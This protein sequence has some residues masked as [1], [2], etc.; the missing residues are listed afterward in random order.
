MP[1][2]KNTK[3]DAW[4]K[5][6]PIG[7]F[8][9]NEEKKDEKDK[10][11]RREQRKEQQQRKDEVIA[12]KFVGKEYAKSSPNQVPWKKILGE[13]I[14]DR[15]HKLKNKGHSILAVIDILERNISIQKF[16]KENP[17][18]KNKVLT[19]IEYNVKNRYHENIRAKKIEVSY[20]N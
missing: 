15:I 13:S 8:K 11:R 6:N 14:F 7:S 20:G 17:D 18:E 1:E 2:I 12:G 9:T 16:I 5:K 19:R 10:C 3:L 4:R